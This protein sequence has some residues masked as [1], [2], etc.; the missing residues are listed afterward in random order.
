MFPSVS[1]CDICRAIH[2]RLKSDSDCDTRIKTRA[3]GNQ[4][5]AKTEL[6]APIIDSLKMKYNEH[7]VGMA[8]LGVLS[9][10]SE[11]G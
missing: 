10:L 4:Q 5:D 11:V 2:N 6:G 8:P 1:N 3:V 9:F 7:I